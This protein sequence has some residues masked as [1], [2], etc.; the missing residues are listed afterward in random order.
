MTAIRLFAFS[1]AALLS[2]SAAFAQTLYRGLPVKFNVDEPEKHG[3]LSDTMGPLFQAVEGFLGGSAIVNGSEI[4]VSNRGPFTNGHI[5][6]ADGS[7]WSVYTKD[8]AIRVQS[9]QKF[10][11]DMFEI[12]REHAEKV[13]GVVPPTVAKVVDIGIVLTNNKRLQFGYPIG[14]QSFPEI[15]AQVLG[16]LDY[17]NLAFLRSGQPIRFEFAGIRSG[18][19]VETGNGLDTLTWA[20][21]D[22]DVRE[23]RDELGADIVMVY[24]T[25]GGSMAFIGP[26]FDLSYGVVASNSEWL[27]FSTFAHEIGHVL[28]LRHNVE[29]DSTPGPNHGHVWCSGSSCYADIMSYRPDAVGFPVFANPAIKHEGVFTGVPG[30]S[31]AASVASANALEVGDYMIR[32]AGVTCAPSPNRLCLDNGFAVEAVWQKPDLTT[33]VAQAIQLDVVGVTKGGLFT[34]FNP[35]NPELFVKVLNGCPVNG[36]FWVFVS[37]LTNVGVTVIVTDTV[38]GVT[39]FYHNPL[40]RLMPPEAATAGEGAFTCD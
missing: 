4:F 1:L 16:A 33:G 11:C 31:E 9:A 28:G 7:E 12:K 17:I 20:H 35:V 32:K 5:T 26:D 8:G 40:G 10:E 38:A 2:W 14:V 19:F 39:N 29:L 34:F 18:S 30:V 24:S 15:E 21:T 6:L 25:S 23:F 37:G 27:P 36:H 3:G 13:S 22:T